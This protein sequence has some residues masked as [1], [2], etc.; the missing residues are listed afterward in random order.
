[1]AALCGASVPVPETLAANFILWSDQSQ[2]AHHQGRAINKPKGQPG[3]ENS[4]RKK[5]FFKKSTKKFLGIW[6]GDV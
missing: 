5:F 6:A 2:G 3:E 1:M 4:R